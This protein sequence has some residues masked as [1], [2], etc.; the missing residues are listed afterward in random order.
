MSCISEAADQAP[1]TSFGRQGNP[2]RI[3][4]IYTQD[5]GTPLILGDQIISRNLKSPAFPGSLSD[6]LCVS[7]PS[8]RFPVLN[9]SCRPYPLSPTWLPRI[10]Y[11]QLLFY[12]MSSIDTN[13]LLSS[14]RPSRHWRSWSYVHVSLTFIDLFYAD[15]NWSTWG[16]TVETLSICKD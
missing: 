7:P 3:A 4:V 16:S 10:M 9:P 12:P 2:S 8:F 14:F 13:S 11:V 1:P 15:T 5:I 6:S